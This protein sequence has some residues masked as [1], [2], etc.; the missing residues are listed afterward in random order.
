VAPLVLSGTG[1]ALSVPAIQSTVMGSV[2]QTEL[3]KASGTLS[4]VRQLGAVFG[5]GILAAV[6]TAFGGYDS[7]AEFSDGFVAAMIASAVLSLAG[8]L[9]SVVLPARE[10]LP[11]LV[12]A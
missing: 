6:F 1:L 11:E 10:P 2:A 4:T 12:A 7:P 5:V 3:G 8:A 9:T